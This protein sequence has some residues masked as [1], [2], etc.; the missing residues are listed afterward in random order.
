MEVRVEVEPS[1]GAGACVG[2]EAENRGEKRSWVRVT[3]PRARGTWSWVLSLR[4]PHVALEMDLG[5]RRKGLGFSLLGFCPCV[6]RLL[7][8][9][10]RVVAAGTGDDVDG[11]RGGVQQELRKGKERTGVSSPQR[12]AESDFEATEGESLRNK[13]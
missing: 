12:K 8:L 13:E 6:L 5:S 3:T 10:W 11:V 9:S 1:G 2:E 4:E 7:S